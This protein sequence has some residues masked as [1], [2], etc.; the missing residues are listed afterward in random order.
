M[1]LQI[2]SNVVNEARN[3]SNTSTE[4]SVEDDKKDIESLCNKKSLIMDGL[5]HLL[6]LVKL[7]PIRT[8]KPSTIGLPTWS[9]VF[10]R[11]NPTLT[12]NS[13]TKQGGQVERELT[14]SS[15]DEANTYQQELSTRKSSIQQ[16]IS[17]SKQKIII[18]DKRVPELEV[19]AA[20]RN[21]KE[22]ARIAAE[23]KPLIVERI[24][25]QIEME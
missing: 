8:S 22:A 9:L 14:N 13:T 15:L 16:D 5:Q 4:Q 6:T 19:V 25:I 23:A 1:E 21:F 24:D 10:R 2:E 18:I 12:P 20:A 7:K 3:A 17:S 11:F